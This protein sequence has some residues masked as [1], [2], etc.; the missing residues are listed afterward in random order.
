MRDINLVWYAIKIMQSD[1]GVRIPCRP[2]NWCFHQLL[3]LARFFIV[4]YSVIMIGGVLFQLCFGQFKFFAFSFLFWMMTFGI[5]SSNLDPRIKILL[6]III[7]FV[8]TGQ[9]IKH[10]NSYFNLIL[11]M[12]FWLFNP[13]LI[14]S[15]FENNGR[16][17][18]NNCPRYNQTYCECVCNFI[19]GTRLIRFEDDYLED[20]DLEDPD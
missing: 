9:E 12:S 8:I 19:S 10:S 13:F 15:F 3:V 14:F 6:I 7:L 2:C 20:D 18:C 11:K 16:C 5:T 4:L 17:I 1:F